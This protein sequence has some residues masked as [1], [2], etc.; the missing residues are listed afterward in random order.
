[1]AKSAASRC[2]VEIFPRRTGRSRGNVRKCTHL[3]TFCRVGPPPRLRGAGG[4]SGCRIASPCPKGAGRSPARSHDV[5]E[6]KERIVNIRPGAAAVKGFRLPGAFSVR[7][8]S[9]ETPRRPHPEEAALRP[10]RRRGWWN[11]LRHEAKPG[12]CPPP[13]LVLA[14]GYAAGRGVVPQ[15]R[16]LTRG[17]RDN[18]GRAPGGG[19]QVDVAPGRRLPAF[20]ERHRHRRVPPN[21]QVAKDP[22]DPRSRGPAPSRP[23]VVGCRSS[24]YRTA[25]T[26]SPASPMAARLADRRTSRGN[27][28]SPG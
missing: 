21:R 1:M 17:P 20:H 25:E 22:L 10:S 23:V 11:S 6:L 19:G 27:G 18:S 4:F 28:R 16:R 13:L 9:F 12:Q 14:A 24:R 15:P 2:R 3:W 8:F 5:Q 26:I 7:P